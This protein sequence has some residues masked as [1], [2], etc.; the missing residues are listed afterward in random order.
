MAFLCG[1]QMTNR[2][3]LKIQISKPEHETSLG[4]NICLSWF[5]QTITPHTGFVCIDSAASE[6][7]SCW[8]FK[9]QLIGW[10]CVSLSSKVAGSVKPKSVDVEIDNRPV[11]S[12][13]Y[14]GLTGL[15][16]VMLVQVI[17]NKSIDRYE[18]KCI[19][20]RPN[21]H[22]PILAYQWRL[23]EEPWSLQVPTVST[24]WLTWWTWI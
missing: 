8:D 5:I 10:W 17:W 18:L 6:S 16:L 13:R 15:L 11:M 7:W 21:Q 22:P 4:S 19:F 23:W 1:F 9:L 12:K 14:R 24:L 3:K 20:F 2:F